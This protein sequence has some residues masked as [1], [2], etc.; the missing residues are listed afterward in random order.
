MDES[1]P[2]KRKCKICEVEKEYT[3]A[4]WPSSKGQPIGLV[5]RP[6]SKHRRRGLEKEYR[7]RRVA[8]RTRN[9]RDMAGKLMPQSAI[10]RSV[11]QSPVRAKGELPV[12]QLEV[13]TAL[14]EGAN[15]LNRRSRYI[16]AKLLTYA[17]DPTSPHHEWV[18]KLFADRMLPKKLFEDLGLQAAGVKTGAGASRPTVN[19]IVQPAT[20]P[21]RGAEPSVIIV[22]GD[23]E[24]DDESVPE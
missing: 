1:Q 6:C 5:C 8:A 16:L 9:L 11:S 15:V 4:E 21:V 17:R 2:I 20:S 10:E 18:M 3:T 23:S 19:I 24:R 7:Q 14:R 12:K 13:A 22:D